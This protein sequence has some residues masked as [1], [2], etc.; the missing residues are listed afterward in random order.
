MNSPIAIVF[1]GTSGNLILDHSQ[2]FAGTIAGMGPSTPGDVADLGDVTFAT[3]TK[4]YSGSA[5]SEVLTIS[6]GTRTARLSMIGDFT[7]SSFNLENDG[8]G[9]VEFY[10]P[11]SSSNPSGRSRAG[12]TAS[13]SSAST[14]R[15]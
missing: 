14:E 2:T 15:G 13:R 9:H 3:A 5:T 12:A 1:A 10:D 7:T 11:A 8:T 6:D 4:S